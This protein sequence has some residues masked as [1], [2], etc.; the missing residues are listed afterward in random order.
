MPS[1]WH[2]RTPRPSQACYAAMDEVLVL[3]RWASSASAQSLRC[4][5]GDDPKVTLAA[6]RTG[7]T[8]KGYRCFANL[9]GLFSRWRI[10]RRADFGEAPGA[11]TVGEPAEVADAH[12]TSG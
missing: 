3:A 2:E 6:E 12:E 1:G 4:Q 11:A 9:S 8:L 5:A 7:V 10:D